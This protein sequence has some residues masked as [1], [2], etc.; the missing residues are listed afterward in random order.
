MEVRAVM[1]N[2]KRKGCSCAE[3]GSV[4]DVDPQCERHGIHGDVGKHSD[5]VSIPDGVHPYRAYLLRKY[6]AVHVGGTCE[7]GERFAEKTVD[8]TAEWL[9][10]MAG[11]LEH[12]APTD[13]ARFLHG[14]AR[15]IKR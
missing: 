9:H 8:A 2:P 13:I 5:A 14:L 11:K 10:E 4:F 3:Y 7:I 12:A 1:V 6:C 15:E